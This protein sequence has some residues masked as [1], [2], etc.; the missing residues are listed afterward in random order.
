[1]GTPEF[2]YDGTARDWPLPIGPIAS[3]RLTMLAVYFKIPLPVPIHICG[4]PVTSTVV[5]TEL[6]LAYKYKMLSSPTRF[7]VV[8]VVECAITDFLC[9]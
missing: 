2:T 3:H 6:L 5:L 8:A 1:M 9:C 4:G 7:R